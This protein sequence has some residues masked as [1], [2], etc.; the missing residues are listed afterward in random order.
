MLSKAFVDGESVWPSGKAEEA[1][2]LT[3]AGSSPPRFS[4]PLKSCG[5]QTLSCDYDPHKE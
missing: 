2:K 5:L 1:V 4:C 3:G